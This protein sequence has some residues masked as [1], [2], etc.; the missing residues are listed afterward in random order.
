MQD[1]SI[2]PGAEK[3]R[4]FENLLVSELRTVIVMWN[5]LPRNTPFRP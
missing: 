3:V 2:N 4:Q 1:S 5:L